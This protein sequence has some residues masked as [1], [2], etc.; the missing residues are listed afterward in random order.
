MVRKC[1]CMKLYYILL[2]GIHVYRCPYQSIAWPKIKIVT[3]GLDCLLMV[4]HPFK[5]CCNNIQAR[6]LFRC[7]LEMIAKEIFCNRQC[8]NNATIKHEVVYW[9]F[10]KYSVNQ[11]SVVLWGLWAF[12]TECCVT[13]EHFIDGEIY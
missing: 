9:A 3:G 4:I 13:N 12:I 7:Y 6:E 1:L 2:R 11:Q 5:I 10:S 8:G